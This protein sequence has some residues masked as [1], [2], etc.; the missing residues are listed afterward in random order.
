MG[1]AMSVDFKNINRAINVEVLLEH[2]RYNG[3]RKQ[4]GNEIRIRCPIH[5]S[6]NQLSLSI[7]SAESTFFCHSCGEKGDLLELYKQSTGLDIKAA[8]KE[9]ASL[10]MGVNVKRIKRTRAISFTGTSQE[11]NNSS[12]SDEDVIRC[13][14]D[15]SDNDKDTYFKGKGLTPPP[16]AKYGR[17]PRG[18]YATMVPFITINKAL[19]SRY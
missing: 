10:F 16:I 9:L 13:W 19:Q 15:A 11:K 3:E 18:H 14:N 7:N 4:Q 2:M 1:A 17:N 12:Y 5:G 6:D 8:A